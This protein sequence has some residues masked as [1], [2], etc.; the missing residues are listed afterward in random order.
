MAKTGSK[1]YTVITDG[2]RDKITSGEYEPNTWLSETQLINDHG[3]TRYAARQVIHQLAL[4]G[5]VTVVDGKG[6]YVRARRDRAAYTDHRDITTASGPDGDRFTDTDTPDWTT[7]EQPGTY[8]ADATTDVALTMGVP[9]HTPL[10]VYD[11]LL[12]HEARRV[13]HRLYLPV[14]T[15]MDNTALTDNPFRAPAELYT[16][17]T[18]AGHSL[19]WT[20]TVRAVTP[21]GDDSTTLRV[22]PGGAVLTTRRLTTDHTGH[23]LALEETRRNAD[24][25]QLAYTVTPSGTSAPTVPTTR[26]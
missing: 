8:R 23:A 22:P 21:T 19:R 1:T 3:I 2:L 5:L 12:G 24:D 6:S 14:A 4:E 11:R 20:E 26:G 16:L 7:V 18:Q 10:F 17:L 15:C 9:E 25:T 13:S